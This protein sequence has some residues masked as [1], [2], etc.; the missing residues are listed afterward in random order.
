MIKSGLVSSLLFAESNRDEELDLICH[1][2]IVKQHKSNKA[3]GSHLK[4]WFS[5]SSNHFYHA[6]YT[7]FHAL[8]PPSH[9]CSSPDF[10]LPS[11]SQ[12]TGS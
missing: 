6:Q 3:V 1:N 10:P 2:I 8:Y 4:V 5:I 12:R 9:L 7:T 11:D